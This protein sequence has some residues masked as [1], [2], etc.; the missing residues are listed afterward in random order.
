[1]HGPGIRLREHIVEA[2]HAER[3]QDALEHDVV[4]QL[5]LFWGQTP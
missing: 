5:V 1:M 3:R 2:A 4:E